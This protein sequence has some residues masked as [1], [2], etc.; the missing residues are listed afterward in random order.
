MLLPSPD[1]YRE[2]LTALF[3]GHALWFPD[4]ANLYE[5]VSIGDVGYV[6]DGY[7]VRMF[8][9]LL[10][11]DNPSNYS[12]YSEEASTESMP[13]NYVCLDMGRFNNVRQ[14]TLSKGDYYSRSL[15]VQ[16]VANPAAQIPGEE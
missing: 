7:F 6:K 9:V 15:A 1:V 14:T 12:H 10:G 16:E 4:P 3:H 2:Q 8:N 13:E 11:W 5:R